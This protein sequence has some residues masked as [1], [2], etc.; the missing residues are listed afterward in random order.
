MS[1]VWTGGFF[2]TSTTWETQESKQSLILFLSFSHWG[3]VALGLPWRCRG[4]EPSCQCRR[5]QFNLWVRN[6]PWRRKWQPTPVFLPGKS[7]G[8]RCLVGYSPRSHEKSDTTE[9]ARTHELPNMNSSSHK[10]SS[11][12]LIVYFLPC[13]YCSLSVYYLALSSQELWKV[14][15]GAFCLFSV[16]IS[17]WEDRGSE[18]LNRLLKVTQPVHARCRSGGVSG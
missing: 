17:R 13:F 2:T 5:H 14:E 8:Q 9:H 18:S 10:G 11:R 6:I 12:F 16:P 3:V 1:L 7:H 15:A 4:K